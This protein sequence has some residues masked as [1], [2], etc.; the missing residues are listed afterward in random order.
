MCATENFLLRGSRLVVL[1]RGVF[2]RGLG[3]RGAPGLTD[4]RRG[5]E[6]SRFGWTQGRPTAPTLGDGGRG[7]LRRDTGSSG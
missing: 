4:H 5:L 7:D 6:W 3:W 2:E 1:F